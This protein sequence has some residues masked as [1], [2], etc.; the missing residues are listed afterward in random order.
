LVL[1][2]VN[3][4]CCAVLEP[5]DSTAN[6]EG[7]SQLL[8]PLSVQLAAVVRTALRTSGRVV[9]TEARCLQL[10]PLIREATCADHGSH[11]ASL[12]RTH[13]KGRRARNPTE[14]MM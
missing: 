6:E 10:E 14:P 5:H 4:R 7:M 12:S 13:V 8:C 3:K 11:E 9:D 2:K 1:I